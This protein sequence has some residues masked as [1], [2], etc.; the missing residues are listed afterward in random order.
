MSGRGITDLRVYDAQDLVGFIQDGPNGTFLAY[1]ADVDEP[2]GSFRTAGEASR[3]ISA[4]RER[5]GC[6]RP[7]ADP[8]AP[9]RI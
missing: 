5:R 7:I 8:G 4:A 9:V 2:L 1:A 6:R 3:A